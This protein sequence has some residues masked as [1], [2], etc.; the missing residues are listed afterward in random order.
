MV[1]IQESLYRRR[2]VKGGGGGGGGGVGLT[3]RYDVETETRINI[4]QKMSGL[5]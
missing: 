4:K 2:R 3:N 5:R 1:M